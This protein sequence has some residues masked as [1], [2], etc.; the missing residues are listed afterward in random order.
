M[1]ATYAMASVR[2]SF[3]ASI[4]RWYASTDSRG[5]VLRSNPSTMFSPI[6][7]AMPWPF[8][9]ISATS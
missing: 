7:A 5:R 6:S 3:S 9:G 1:S 4:W 2:L 8:G